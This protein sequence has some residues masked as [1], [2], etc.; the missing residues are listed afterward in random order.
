VWT[1]LDADALVLSAP[2][3]D[4]VRVPLA[5]PEA[6]PVTVTVWKSTCKALP[7]SR[8]ADG[9]LSDYL[10]THCRLVYM[11]EST[12]RTS[13]PQY[14][15]YGKLVSFADGYAF[16]VVG[17]ASLESLNARLATGGH[18]PLPMNRFRPNIVVSGSNA[19]DED[20]WGEVRV[21]EAVLRGVKPC[22]RCEVTTTDQ[23]T[24]ERQ[25]PEPLATLATF[26]DSREFG[27]MFGMN[28]VTERGGVIAVGDEVSPA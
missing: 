6:P 19:F 1:D 21:G 22:G 20:R 24:G 7:A 8:E 27:V 2:D 4:E 26:R 13:N 10:G 17:E 23:S 16:L 14:A 12:Q 18:A 5:V 3:R 15:G 11:P 28:F 9:W 25:G